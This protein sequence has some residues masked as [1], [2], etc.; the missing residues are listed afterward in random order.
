MRNRRTTQF[1]KM[2]AVGEV[3]GLVGA[4]QHVG[5][6]AVVNRSS[7]RQHL[8]QQTRVRAS[9]TVAFAKAIPT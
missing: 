9:R 8:Q 1:G 4:P 5:G 2:L 3:R 7:A 6:Y